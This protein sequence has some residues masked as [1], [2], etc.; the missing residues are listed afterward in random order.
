MTVR[1][2]GAPASPGVG[3]GTAYVLQTEPPPVGEHDDPKGAYAAAAAT[4]ARA[5]SD[6]GDRSAAAGRDD[7]A[8]ILRAQALMAD[9]PMLADEVAARLDGAAPLGAALA[10]AAATV[11]TALLESGSEYLAARAADVGEIVR[12]IR[13]AL[14]GQEPPSLASAPAG[15]VIVATAL[16]A[17]D[18]AA[19]DPAATAGFVTA[20]GGPT[21]HVA[22]IARSLGIPAVVGVSG[23]DDQVAA[24]ARV[25]LNG[26]T[27]QVVVDPDDD[28][29]ARF[30]A[31]GAEHRQ[32]VESAAAYAGARVAFGDRPMTI[33]ANAGGPVDVEAAISAGADG[34]G[35]YRTE[36][37]F[38]EA[39]RP[40]SEDEQFTVYRDAVAAFDHPVVIRMFDIG[41]DKPA[42]YLDLPA[43]ENPFLGV[44]GMRLYETEH[45]LALGQARAL[46]RAAT[47]GDLWVMAPM[48]TTVADMES[49]RTLFD[50][51]AGQLG[52]AGVEHRT[53][54]LGAM[55]EVPAA[56]LAAPRLLGA[57]DFLSIGTND[58][59]QY[60]MAADRTSGSLAS[61]SDAAHPAVLRLCALTAA[62]ASA[63]GASVAVCGEAAADPALAVLFGAMGMDKLSVAG[64]SVNVVKQTIA[65][66]D[67][68]AAT[69]ALESALDAGSAAEVREIVGRLSG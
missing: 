39:A 14:A 6:M 51:A 49:I 5:L 48:V 35:L 2:T 37:L 26:S 50:E 61:Y 8:E 33:A 18:T 43:E 36:F 59:T 56:A 24:G 13:F 42:P 38:L 15:S 28:T 47:H 20:E 3:D 66:V 67:P 27:G 30:A 10:E 63:A 21:G 57:A 41:G 46:L 29:A 7:A 31:A 53:P 17:A 68:A 62:A 60:T 40:P 58:L 32:K 16:S 54:R 34:I 69:G 4:A 64:S 55:V 23:L 11:T 65:E 25:V 9:D 19:L 45:D 1:L 12:R 44:R 22:V 52:A